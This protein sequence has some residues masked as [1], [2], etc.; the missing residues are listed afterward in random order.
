MCTNRKIGREHGCFL[1]FIPYTME[2][3][4]FILGIDLYNRLSEDLFYH[5]FC[6]SIYIKILFKSGYPLIFAV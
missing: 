5:G 2:G 4:I 3:Y 1:R 6:A